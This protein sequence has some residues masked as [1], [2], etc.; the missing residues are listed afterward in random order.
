MKEYKSDY[1]PKWTLDTTGMEFADKS[2]H[3]LGIVLKVLARLKKDKKYLV[4]SRWNKFFNGILPD[5]LYYS[6][7]YKNFTVIDFSKGL[8]FLVEEGFVKE[9]ILEDKGY[10]RYSLVD[11][12]REQ[13]IEQLR[14][15]V[16]DY[17]LALKQEIENF[18]TLFDTPEKKEGQRFNSQLEAYKSWTTST[19]KV[20]NEVAEDDV[21]F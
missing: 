3:I 2:W 12:K 10:K 21:P 17:D 16:Q 11:D 4:M 7:K 13:V 19:K 5:C 20:E 18:I 15:N 1:Q 6:E 9:E 14:A 8:K